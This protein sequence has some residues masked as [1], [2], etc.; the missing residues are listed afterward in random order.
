MKKIALTLV[1]ALC[2]ASLA[3]AELLV[4]ANP[5]GQGKMAF[6]GAYVLDSNY[7]NS[8]GMS[9]GSIGGYFGYGITDKLDAYAQLGSATASGLPVGISG[10][11]ATGYGASLKYTIIDEGTDIPVSV[12][13]GGG[14]K[15]FNNKT[16]VTGLGDITSTA[17]QIMLGV[18]VSKV[19]APLVPYGAIAYRSNSVSTANSNSTQIDLTIGTA[20]AWSMQGAVMIEYTMQS[21]TPQAGGSYT[22]SEIAASVAYKI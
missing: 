2:V 1:L 14:Y 21:I 16:T 3:S 7:Q 13:L 15:S 17:S 5:L 22:G 6:S 10:M 8:S 11:S 12:A 18:G 4:T 9:L 19:M 20:I